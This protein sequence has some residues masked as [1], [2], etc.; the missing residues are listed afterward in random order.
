MDTDIFSALV[1]PALGS[2]TDPASGSVISPAPDSVISLGLSIIT[3]SVAS[4][5]IN[6]TKSNY[7]YGKYVMT[8]DLTSFKLYM[9]VI[10]WIERIPFDKTG[11]AWNYMLGIQMKYEERR[12]PK[13]SAT[14]LL[15]WQKRWEMGTNNFLS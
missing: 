4:I 8:E 13:I 5:V 7:F 2:I 15:F 11:K 14:S 9:K 1:G 6:F 12:W 3:G 10:I